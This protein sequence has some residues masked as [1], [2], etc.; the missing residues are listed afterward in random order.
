MIGGTLISSFIVDLIIFAL[1]FGLFFLY[2]KVRSRR[3]SSA[4]NQP[5]FYEAECSVTTVFKGVYAYSKEDILEHCRHGGLMY[6]NFHKAALKGLVVTAVL[7]T[8]LL[9]PTY[10]QGEQQ[11]NLQVDELAIAHVLGEN[12]LLVAPVLCIVAFSAV[13][14]YTAYLYY[15][16]S[17]T[18]YVS[19]TQT[20]KLSYDN[21]TVE[22]NGLPTSIP[23]A[24]LSVKLSSFLDSEFPEAFHSV[25]VVPDYTEKY[26]YQLQLNKTLELLSHFRDYQ[27][28]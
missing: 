1:L 9:L 5:V 21:F 8:A 7:A 26:K 4:E 6:L 16:D 2:R 14:Y 11:V 10:L 25:Y 3:I 17:L 13:F 22:I 20:K 15:K 19:S 18:N 27:R 24:E 12:W 28:M 23:P